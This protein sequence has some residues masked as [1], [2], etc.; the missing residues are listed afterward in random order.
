MPRYSV[1]GCL[2]EAHTW[3]GKLHSVQV[4]DVWTVFPCDDLIFMPSTKNESC[5][6]FHGPRAQDRAGDAARLWGRVIGVIGDPVEGLD[7][8]MTRRAAE[9]LRQP[10]VG[11]VRGSLV[12][13]PMDRMSVEG[14]EDVLLKIVEEF[15]GEVVRPYL[16][17]G[18]LGGV[19]ATIRSRCVDVWSPGV[20]PPSPVYAQAEEIVRCSLSRNIPGL[21]DALGEKWKEDGEAILRVIPEVLMKTRNPGTFPLW[22]RLR[23]LLAYGGGGDDVALHEALA[24]FMS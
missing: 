21:I 18:D 8:E 23:P 9:L 22:L 16:W 19:R 15:D 5:R 2:R 6:L 3:R 12:V 20:T 1:C 4:H 11:D 14:I 7:I 13:G 24:E 10:V 17:A